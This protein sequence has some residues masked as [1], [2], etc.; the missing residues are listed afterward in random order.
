MRLDLYLVHYMD[1]ESRTKAQDLIQN[2]NVYVNTKL[3]AKPSLEVGEIDAVEIKNQEILKFVSRAGLKLEA[4]LLKLK[5]DLNEKV[6]L[7]VGQSAGGF[8]DCCLQSGAC[9]VIGFDVGE[10]QLHEK[11]KNHP[12][13]KYFEKQ[14]AKNI[15]ENFEFIKALPEKGVDLIVCDV[16]FISLTHIVPAVAS[17]LK[18]DGE[19]LFLVKPQFECGPENLDKNGIVKNKNVYLDIQL[20][21]KKLFAL[22]FNDVQNY[23][24]CPV[25]GKEGNT[26]FFIYGH[27]KK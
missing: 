12:K 2:Q 7:D 18:K 24:E 1:I 27:Q 3:A 26:E 19:Y 13:V 23:I 21:L 16:S 5:I 22:H 9:Q 11:I 6:I 14:N 25:R 20:N 17:Y 8:T 15:H 4:A 10:N